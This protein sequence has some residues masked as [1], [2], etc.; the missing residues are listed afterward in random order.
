MRVYR[1]SLLG[2]CAIALVT[3]IAYSGSFDGEF[4]SDDVRRVRD[5][6]YIR[7]LDA[8]HIKNIF[9]NFDGANYMPLKVL[10]LAVD[11]RLWGPAPRGYHITN[12]ILHIGCAVLIY[13]ILMRL[14]LSPVAACLT[15]MLWAVHPLQVESVAWISERKNVLSGLF[16]F[17][18]FG[19]YLRFSERASVGSYLGVLTLYALALLSKMNTMVLPVICVAY[20]A[21]FRFRLR[22]RHVMAA[23]PMVVMAAV[24]AWYNLAGNPIHG[25]S[26]H[27][28]SAI[29]TWL[30]SAVVFFRYIGHTLVPLGLRYWYD[31]PLRD[32]VLDPPVAFS[33]LG[34]AAIGAAIVWLIRIRQSSVF[35]ILWFGITLGP[36]LNIFP[37]RSLMNDRYM[38]LA[39]LG[40]LAL[41]ATHLD[42]LRSIAA[43]R[44]VVAAAAAATLAC[45]VVT[46]RQ[47][48]VWDTPLTMWASSAHRDAFMAVDPR[49]AR[50]ATQTQFEYLGQALEKDP[51]SPILLNNVGALHFQ[52]GRFHEA[53]ARFEQA[54]RLAPDS[55]NI[56]LNLGRAYAQLGRLPDA[57]RKL[58]RAVELNP[59]SFVTHRYL[60]RLCLVL[61]DLEGARRGV[62]ALARTRPHPSEARTWREE[63][64]A[65][66]RLEAA[67]R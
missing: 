11:Y 34:L 46:H 31:V 6:L 32:S 67:S 52:L 40:L 28:G 29:I 42:A 60:T 33:L 62:A 58:E 48:E 63:R 2:A 30:T 53:L 18:A 55:P 22:W 24:A 51:D 43:R 35:W 4:V 66:E 56:P 14:G 23:L 39:L 13:L 47:V 61:N 49:H 36:M 21:A 45:V 59:H 27:G 26:Y 57:R 10:S 65:L 16:F 8:E 19:V 50:P 25:G 5:N 12:L 37:F 1:T 44:R 38:Y 54:E 41:A 7:S 3:L 64:I 9:R 17:A 20:E 15:A